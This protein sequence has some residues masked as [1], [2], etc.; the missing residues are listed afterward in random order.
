[1]HK[2]SFASLLV[3]V[4]AACASSSDTPLSLDPA[5]AAVTS[6]VGQTFQLKAGQTAR[7]GSEGLLVGFRGVAS[8]SRC[9][10]DVQCV[11]AGD[12][13][14]RVPVTVGRADWTSLSLHTTLEP[15]TATFRNYKITLVELK[16]APRST[17]RI[18]SNDYVAT[19]RVE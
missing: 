11:W 14:A 6:Q 9:A 5:A 1:M 10:V 15:K 19:L 7:V 4:A 2:L 3:V 13:E 18:D 17:Q 8:D 16:P 12:A